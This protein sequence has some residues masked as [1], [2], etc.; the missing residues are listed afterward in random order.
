MINR[1]ESFVAPRK[2]AAG[3]TDR[4]PPLQ[5]VE[6]FVVVAKEWA[7]LHPVPCLTAAFVIGATLAWLIKRR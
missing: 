4:Q 7:V 6:E 2:S 3:P 5:Q 1:I